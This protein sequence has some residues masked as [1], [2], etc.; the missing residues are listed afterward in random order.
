LVYNYRQFKVSHLT[1]IGR[2]DL[3]INMGYVN[4][5]F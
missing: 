2:V 4:I 3:I 5:Y 1:M